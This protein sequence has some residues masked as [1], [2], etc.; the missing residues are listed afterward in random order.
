MVWWASWPF[1]P[2]RR[3]RQRRG[4]SSPASSHVRTST[5]SEGFDGTPLAES[6][7]YDPFLISALERKWRSHDLASLCRM[8][9]VGPMC[10][11][12]PLVLVLSPE[13]CALGNGTI[14]VLLLSV[15]SVSHLKIRLI[16]Y[17]DH[18]RRASSRGRREEGASGVAE[19][20]TLSH[21][22]V[23]GRAHTRVSSVP[24]SSHLSAL[25]APR[26]VSASRFSCF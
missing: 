7:A 16:I 17:S 14:N 22:S 5:A 6:V 15:R 8:C 9:D 10:A 21:T 2:C 20:H 18:E 26:G 1:S 23:A 12:R 19:I 3:V 11:S 25:G 24:S 4:A 13:T